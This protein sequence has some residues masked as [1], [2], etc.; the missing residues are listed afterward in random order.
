M[1]WMGDMGGTCRHC[2][3]G[4][5]TP[6]C[7]R[8]PGPASMRALSMLGD[9]PRCIYSQPLHCPRMMLKQLSIG[10]YAACYVASAAPACLPSS[11]HF[12]RTRWPSCR[13]AGVVS[14]RQQRGRGNWRSSGW[15]SA[16]GCAPRLGVLLRQ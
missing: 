5:G 6:T 4:K 9:Y 3:T 13:P 12:C 16:A 15:G 8:S 10:N 11:H 7:A 2:C 14:P 1:A